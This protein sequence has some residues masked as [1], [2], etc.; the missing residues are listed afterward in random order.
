LRARRSLDLFNRHWL[1]LTGRPR[2]KGWVAAGSRSCIPTIAFCAWKPILPPLVPASRFGQVPVRLA[3]GGYHWIVDTCFPMFVPDG[4]FAGLV[5][6]GTAG[7]MPEASDIR[8]A[9]VGRAPG[10]A[11]SATGPSW[12]Y[13]ALAF[14][15][16]AQGR[17]VY[18][19]RAFERLFVAR[20]PGKAD[21]D[22]RLPSREHHEAASVRRP[23]HSRHRGAATIRRSGAHAGRD[24]LYAQV[25]R[26]SITVQAPG[27]DLRVE[28]TDNGKGISSERIHD[29]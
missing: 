10:K 24:A 5:S 1:T 8:G 26:V 17:Y 14:M 20:V 15:K 28:V 4:G 3:D 9:E 21:F 23:A 13:P 11:G 16:N 25:S 29:P 2:I 18:V 27:N 12:S 22:F 7:L 19:K 6:M